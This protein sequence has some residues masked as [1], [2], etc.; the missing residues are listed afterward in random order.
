MK[1]KKLNYLRSARHQRLVAA[2]PC[3]NCGLEGMTQAAHSN[4]GKGMGIKACDSQLMALCVNCHREHDQGGIFGSKFE[5]WQ[6][7][8]SLVQATRAE[9]QMRGQW[10]K[11]VEDAFA[12]AFPRLWA[13]ANSNV[14]SATETAG[15]KKA[16]VA[17]A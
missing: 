11:E 9:L 2:L 12:L 4:Y 5:R 3:V 14:E 15:M 10:M 6:K 7:E 13:A 16:A 8:A 1:I 17:A